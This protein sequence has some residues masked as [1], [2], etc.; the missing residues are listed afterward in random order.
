MVPFYVLFVQNLTIL[1][2]ITLSVLL[3][4]L[5]FYLA[6]ICLYEAYPISWPLIF[7]DLLFIVSLAFT[8]L[9]TGV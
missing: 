8:S 4:F 3:T 5:V 2:F 6:G 7:S 9:L 1:I